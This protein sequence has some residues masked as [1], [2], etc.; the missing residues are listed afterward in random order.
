MRGCSAILLALVVA[1]SLAVAAEREAVL[2]H[3]VS[4]VD[5]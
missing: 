4:V 2:L 5:G 1:A 3:A